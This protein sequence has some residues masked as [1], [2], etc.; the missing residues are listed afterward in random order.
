MKGK[1]LETQ[2]KALA[3]IGCGF[4]TDLPKFP[5]DPEQTILDSLDFFWSDE[6]L[7]VMLIGVL[8]HRISSLI[9]VERLVSLSKN[10]TKDQRIV[11]M[12]I[13]DKMIKL[14]DRRYKLIEQKLKRRGMKLSNFPKLYSSP[15]YL[16]KHGTDPSFKKYGSKIP[17]IF[18]EDPKKFFTLKHIVSNHPWLKIRALVGANYRADLIYLKSAGIVESPASSYKIMGCERATAYRLWD[19]IALVEDLEKLIA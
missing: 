14:G 7:F 18:N 16:E 12:V 2:K 3:S 10:L 19:S 5:A 13:A 8:S 17:N 4:R 9:H 1:S 6:K 11:L 15:F